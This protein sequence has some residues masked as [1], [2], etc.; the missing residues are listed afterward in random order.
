MNT[1]HTKRN[2]FEEI[3]ASIEEFKLYNA[4]KITLKTTTLKV[5][6]LLVLTGDDIVR[7]RRKLNVSRPVFAH[8]LRINPRKLES[9]EQNRSRVS[10]E[11]ATLI[12]LVEKDP[13]TLEKIRQL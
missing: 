1:K 9:W 10:D 6:P 5:L 7:I 2:L 12:R 11:A 4:G 3:K 8:A 13:A